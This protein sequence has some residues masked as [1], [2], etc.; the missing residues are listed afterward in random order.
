MNPQWVRLLDLLQMNVR[1]V[2]CSGTR[3]YGDDG[4]EFLDFLSGY[5]VHNIGHNH[6]QVIAALEA[7]L[8]QEGPAMVQSHA[9]ELAGQLADELCRRAGGHLSKAFFCSS[10]SEGIET[11]I[12]FARARTQRNGL[13]YA[14]G[15]FHGLTTGAL[16]LMGDAFWREGFG[17]LLP[18]CEAVPFGDLQAL[19]AKLAGK[20]FAALVLEPIQGEAGIRIP[21]P[22]YLAEAQYLCHRYGTLLVLDEVQTGLGRTGRFLA[23]HH[24]GVQ[25]DMVVLAKALSGGL[26]PVGAVLMTE[27]VYDAVYDSLKRSIVHTSTYSENALAMRAGLA[28]LQVLDEEGLAGRA[29]RMGHSLRDKLREA[30]DDFE[31][32]KDV[33]GMGL[34]CGIEFD[35]P[36]QIRMRAA[37]EAFRAVHGGLFGQMVVMNLFR[38]GVLTQMCG[39]N[40]MVLKVAPPLVAGEAEVDRFVEQVRAVMELVHGST[41]FWTD[42][43]GM[44]RR[45]VNI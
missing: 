28:T 14:D 37:F 43:L 32:V 30:L 17:P 41:T 20:R 8:R 4:R 5:C 9:P 6:P 40:F 25:P 11:A 33:R 38:R 31:M 26:V 7:E 21:D 45:A 24:Y 16:S 1:Y 29:E 35:K 39:N 2:R 13:L 3:L 22:Q 10:G 27:K 18:N 12:K 42:A 34:F 19:K 36:K 44:A 15:A 23:A